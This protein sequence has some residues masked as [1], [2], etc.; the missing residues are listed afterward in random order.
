MKN[1]NWPTLNLTRTFA[2]PPRVP[3]PAK[4]YKYG[5]WK[6]ILSLTEGRSIRIGTLSYYRGIESQDYVRGDSEEGRVDYRLTHVE[7]SPSRTKSLGGGLIVLPPQPGAV[8]NGIRC[9]HTS[10]D[11]YIYCLSDQLDQAVCRRF[12]GAGSEIEDIGLLVKL[13][14]RL[15]ETRQKVKV[16]ESGIFPVC[17]KSNRMDPEDSVPEDVVL[18]KRPRDSVDHEWRYVATTEEEETTLLTVV[19]F[20]PNPFGDPFRMR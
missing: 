18:M 4:L 12:G 17:Y 1:A 19:D 16:L 9:V 7:S 8:V 20:S 2:L 6:D 13:L 10:R 14:D 15:L 3:F 11:C 5:H